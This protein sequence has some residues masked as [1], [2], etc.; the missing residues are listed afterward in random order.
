MAIPGVVLI[1]DRINPGFKSTREM[2]ETDDYEALQGLA[3]RQQ[4]A[5][6][7][8]LDFTIG[9]R[10]RDDKEFLTK[11]IQAVQ[12]AVDIPL[13][14]DDPAF[15][16]QEHCLNAY[17]ADKAGGE[18][19]MINSISETRWELLDLLKICPLKFIMM[20]SERVEDG[21]GMQNKSVP[22]MVDTVKRMT[23]KILASGYDIEIDDL[24]VDVAIGTLAS[25]TEGLTRNSLDTIKTI[26]S[27]PE[28][29]GIHMSAGMTNL[30]TQLPVMKI[31]DQPLK[32]SLENAFLTLAGPA[33]FDMMLTTPWKDYHLLD[34]DNR[35][36]QAFQ[37]II[38]LD[39][40]DALR[41]LRKL[42][43][44]Q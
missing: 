19:A 27:A 29:K 25:D 17:D 14:F 4:D 10:A 3:L 23:K 31:D 33:G 9:P 20:S 41:R 26:G 16:I 24:I 30:S 8:Y 5:G 11:S 12:E 40:L 1:G 43:K 44:S 39:G 35:V 15:A 42:Y 6:A 34:D 37:E 18:K 21:V 7:A 36:F 32:L 22:D 13:C 38:A 28:L 2:I